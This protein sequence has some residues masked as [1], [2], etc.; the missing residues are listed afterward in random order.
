MGQR[1]SGQV[2]GADVGFEREDFVSWRGE[3]R[4]V[5]RRREHDGSRVVRV[6]AGL[7]PIRM[8]DRDGVRRVVEHVLREVVAAHDHAEQ[9]LD[10]HVRKCLEKRARVEADP[11]VGLRHG[12]TR[13]RDRR[14]G[15]R[16]PTRV[17]IGE[18]E[19]V[20]VRL[21]PRAALRR[22]EVVEHRAEHERHLGDPSAAGARLLAHLR[23]VG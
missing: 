10:R 3:R 7:R 13:R 6:D 8:L 2:E 23:M 18:I 11:S 15:R 5:D 9:E 17:G 14:L 20:A 1:D 22:G 19:R 12:G 4:I 21:R 16:L